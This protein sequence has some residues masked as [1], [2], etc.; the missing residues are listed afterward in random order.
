MDRAQEELQF[1]GIT[2]I[3]KE[4]LNIILRCREIFSRVAL[5]FV[6]PITLIHLAHLHITQLLS[7]NI[8]RNEFNLYDIS[9][10]SPSYA[11]LSNLISSEWTMFWLFKAAYFTFLL[12]LS[13]FSTSAVVYTVASIYTGKEFAF[14]KVLSVVPTVWKRLL[15]T[16][17]WNYAILFTYNLIA[18]VILILQ[19][20]FFGLGPIGILLLVSSLILYT[21]ALAYISI[22]WSLACVV[23]ILE[24][25]KGIKA[26]VRGKNLLR[27]NIKVSAASFFILTASSVAIGT[28]YDNVVVFFVDNLWIRIVVGIACFQLLF[29]V[30]LVGLVVQTVVYFVCKSHHHEF[31][32][33]PLLADHL[34][35][36]NGDY[37]PLQTQD[38]Q[39]ERFSV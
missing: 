15:V 12:F 36:Y 24:D 7:F 31:V 38:V 21:S 10:D 20:L 22:V 37:V 16:F 30:I 27:G 33:K 14:R 3:F 9:N 6:F 26:M 4:S 17:L 19:L 29:M 32:D 25:S 13:L 34:D 23:S 11:K 8:L 39:L 28:L 1:L 2:G 18:L 5:A 35:T